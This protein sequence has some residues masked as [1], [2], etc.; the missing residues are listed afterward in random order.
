MAHDTDVVEHECN[1]KKWVSLSN[2][3]SPPSVCRLSLDDPSS[4]M[5]HYTVMW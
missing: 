4:K 2:S 1:N 3:G 5:V